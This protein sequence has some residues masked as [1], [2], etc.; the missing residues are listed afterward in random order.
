VS[1]QPTP[2]PAT[3]RGAGTSTVILVTFGPTEGVDH[4]KR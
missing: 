4:D 2:G 1:G 3:E